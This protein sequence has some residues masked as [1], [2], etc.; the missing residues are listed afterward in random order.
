MEEKKT[1][2]VQSCGFWG[3]SRAPGRPE[4]KRARKK[5]ERRQERNGTGG[6]GGQPQ[7]KREELLKRGDPQWGS[8]CVSRGRRAG[9]N[10]KKLETDEGSQPFGN[11]KERWRMPTPRKREELLKRGDRVVCGAVGVR[12]GWN[13]KKLETD[14]GSQPFGSNKGTWRFRAQE[15]PMTFG[16][17]IW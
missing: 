17:S 13:T 14:V 5:K 1:D 16:R 3:C 15:G 7:G 9:W 8:G 11:K 10:T 4:P 6:S 12:R 2:E